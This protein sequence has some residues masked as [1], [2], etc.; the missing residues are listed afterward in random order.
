MAL[1]GRISAVL[2]A[3]T[4]SFTREI[5]GARREILDFARQ[6]NG[7]RLNLDNRAL[8]GTLTNLQR[9]ERTLRQIQ[10][11]QAQGIGAGLPDTGR[12]RDQ[13]RVFEDIGRPLTGLKNQVEGFA[14][15]VQSQLYP[16]LSRLQD[17]FQNLYSDI[18]S[19]ATTFDR[20]RDRIESLRRGLVAFG[21]ATAA[22]GDFS[23]LSRS[24]QA[25]TAGADFFQ[26]AAKESLTRALDLRNKA[27]Q[28]PANNRSDVFADLA[29]RSERNADLIERAAARVAAA[30]LRIAN[31]GESPGTLTQA[32]VAQQRL[33]ALTQIQQAT[34]M[35]FDRE[36]TSAQI[37]QVIAPE[38]ERQVDSLKVKFKDLAATL[39]EGGSTRFE[40]LI[41]SVGR[42]IERLN[43]GTASAKAA[44]AAVEAL[45]AA[46]RQRDF[47]K[48]GFR[49]ADKTLR[50]DSERA[51]GDIRKD[52]RIQRAAVTG[53]ARATRV[54]GLR[55]QAALSREEFNRS[56]VS[57]VGDINSRVKELKDSGLSSE[58]D[59]IRKLSSGVNSALKNAFDAKGPKGVALA[60][61]DYRTKLAALTPVI[62]KFEAKVKSAEAAQRRFQ[63]FLAVSGSRSDKLGAD[64]DR[65]ASDIAVARQ[66]AGNFGANNIAGR[67]NVSAE[68]ERQIKTYQK[69]TELQ[70]RIFDKD[71]KN[72]AAKLK[73]IQ[74]VTQAVEQ[75]R[76]A[77]KKAVVDNSEGLV[78]GGQY[79]AAADRAAKNRGSFGVGGA[80]VA[81]LAFQQGLFAIDDFMSATGGLEYKLRAIGNNIT[82]L[83]L[84]LGQSG[85]IPGLSATAGLFIGLAAVMGGQLASAFARFIN[86]TE[87]TE[88]QLK[89]LN[90]ATS[91]HESGVKKLADAYKSLADEIRNIGQSDLGRQRSQI[92]D[93]I[94]ELAGDRTASR[95][96]AAAAA[97]PEISRIRARRG[98][99][100]NRLEKET[101]ITNRVRIQRQ[102]ER[103]KRQERDELASLS[104]KASGA[105]AAAGIRGAASG[106]VEQ[107]R[108]AVAAAGYEFGG[109]DETTIKEAKSALESVQAAMAEFAAFP[110]FNVN[111]TAKAGQAL[112]A[113]KKQLE[114]LDSLRESAAVQ[115]KAGIEG[116]IDDLAERLLKESA[117]IEARLSGAFRR[118]D[119]QLTR[120]AYKAAQSLAGAG[121]IIG[122]AFGE[123]I[124]SSSIQAELDRLA[125]A[126]GQV[127]ELAGN[128][129]TP[130]E[131]AAY[132]ADIDAINAHAEQLKAAAAAT[133]FF[134]DA[135]SKVSDTF[136][137]DNSAFGQR[138]EDARRA[139]I[140]FSTPETRQRRDAA[141][142]EMEE[143]ESRRRGLDR[144][145][146]NAREQVEQ[147][148]KNDPAFRARAGRI[149]EIDRRLS[150]PV[151][152]T[153]P[154]GVYGGT[155]A[156]RAR[157]REERDNLRQQQEAQMNGSMAVRDARWAR[158]QETARLMQLQSADR[159]RELALNPAQK[160]GKELASSLRDLD[161]AFKADG[162]DPAKQSETNR[163]VIE[164]AM[165]ATA[166]AIFGMADEVQNAIVQG[167]SRAA[168]Q[169]SDVSTIQGA[170]ELNRLLRGDDSAKNQNLVE[171]QKQS[172]S[173]DQL[174][175]IA[176]ENGAPPGVFDN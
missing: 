10:R 145:I 139:D 137:T 62:E 39:R 31:E 81:Q 100:E 148:L 160:A 33:D 99:M 161:A 94:R 27:A 110:D 103:S 142:I 71:F 17:G 163:R 47:G 52:F 174:V 63:Q 96:E 23:K 176:K 168:L 144:D 112:A 68:I 175:Q 34:N 7:I 45:A 115:G 93:K 154:E 88:Q 126:L 11:L 30:Q 55:E 124:S 134:T 59:N 40:G 14:T 48:E 74:K 26:P 117:R 169:A 152:E 107:A 73:A 9:F 129:A 121:K 101:D 149:N 66:F 3:N 173:L 156:E 60:L 78:K 171:L 67:R 165:R 5:G 51:R 91:A 42:V 86:D 69:I 41:D 21:R 123:T 15:A 70:Q 127:R 19:G 49:S 38:G 147:R 159:G 29:V 24:L 132:Q 116:A 76:A 128:A 79:D 141:E 111:D 2:T 83:G 13:F 36:I 143:A 151:G 12:L 120:S 8:N 37:R 158:D 6:V 114:T 28:I 138:A 53:D 43:Q 109:G 155:A 61:D 84:L 32:G 72:E 18:D 58:F 77:L 35:A 80:A 1:L 89:V 108:Q 64:L 82:Q 135:M 119:E 150:A 85:L 105:N 97:D 164:D 87:T 131:A 153:T 133:K 172:H 16:E 20:A 166:P 46:G 170:T 140:A 104:A 162:V 57:R 4:Q 113:I 90:A 65:G 157:M 56:T 136:N 118:V 50:T 102:I 92:D 25:N 44:K 95:E 22:A 167:P 122:D 146:A 106:A 98:A 75:Q 130:A 54:L 125:D